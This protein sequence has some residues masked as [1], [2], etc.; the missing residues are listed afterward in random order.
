MHL[1]ARLFIRFGF[2]KLGKRKGRRRAQTD[3]LVFALRLNVADRAAKA[4]AFPF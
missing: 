1:S 4:S 3:S 2:G